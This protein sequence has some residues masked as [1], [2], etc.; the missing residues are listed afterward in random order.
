[1]ETSLESFIQY[2][3]CERNYSSHTV[4]AYKKD[5]TQ[6]LEFLGREYSVADI[7]S[8]TPDMGRDWAASLREGGEKA[9]SIN[10]KIS[11]LRS[12]CR[13]CRRLGTDVR[14][15]DALSALKT[16]KPL[17]AFFKKSEMEAVLTDDP[18]EGSPDNPDIADFALLRDDLVIEIL[19]QTGVRRSELISIKDEDFNFF[20]LTLRIRGKGNKERIIPVGTLLRDKVQG[21]AAVRDKLFGHTDSL[22]VTDKG[23]PAYPQLIYRIVEAK[24]GGAGVRGKKSPHVLRHTFATDMLNGGAEIDAVKSLLGHASLAAT[25]VYTHNSFERIKAAYKKAHPRS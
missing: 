14:A 23:R 12:Y 13:Y 21:Y 11:A 5:L 4:L 22:I 24:M 6:F 15:A 2:L 16:S 19:Y 3:Q 18:S 7:R 1:M 9:S 20:S 10:R 8:A 25:Q 17:P